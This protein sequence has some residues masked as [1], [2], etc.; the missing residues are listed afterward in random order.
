MDIES[1]FG[2]ESVDGAMS[3]DKVRE[4]Q[5]R[6]ARNAAAIAAARQQEQKQKKKEDAV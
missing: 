5:E 6:M 1:F 3:A 4:F 2:N